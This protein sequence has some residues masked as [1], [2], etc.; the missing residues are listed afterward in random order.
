MDVRKPVA[1]ES[2]IADTVSAAGFAGHFATIERT[3]VMAYD[4]SV[5]P[6]EGKSA[7]SARTRQRIYGGNPNV[8]EGAYGGA[9]DYQGGDEQVT[10]ED[11]TTQLLRQ[12]LARWQPKETPSQTLESYARLQ[13]PQKFAQQTY[14]AR[15]MSD[16][17]G[18]GGQFENAYHLTPTAALASQGNNATNQWAQRGGVTYGGQQ[19][20]PEELKRLNAMRGNKTYI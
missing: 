20:D 8:P 9:Q 5:G 4:Q 6:K 19:I 18:P 3:K 16:P 14:A 11:Q 1:G 2:A 7:I 15:Q 12:L 17:W 13:D 10:G